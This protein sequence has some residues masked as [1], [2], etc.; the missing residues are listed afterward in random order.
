[1]RVR[2]CYGTIGYVNFR[3]VSRG[4][5]TWGGEG[6]GF[7][8]ILLKII[9]RGAQLFYSLRYVKFCNGSSL[10]LGVSICRE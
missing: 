8:P 3:E 10:G 7:F 5:E 2:Q 6:S 1:M 9:L 4:E